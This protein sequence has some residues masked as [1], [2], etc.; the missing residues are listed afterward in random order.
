MNPSFRGDRRGDGPTASPRIASC[1]YNADAVDVEVNVMDDLAPVVR[2]AG[3]G[4]DARK[5]REP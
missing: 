3:Y 4:L 1:W 5:E 2:P